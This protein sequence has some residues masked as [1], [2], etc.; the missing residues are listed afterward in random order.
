MCAAEEQPVVP[1]EDPLVQFPAVPDTAGQLAAAPP[2]SPQRPHGC[3]GTRRTPSFEK[4]AARV[5]ASF[6]EHYVAAGGTIRSDFTTV[7]VTM[8]ATTVWERAQRK[9]EGQIPAHH[10]PGCSIRPWGRALA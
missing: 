9:E 1:A 2:P 8:G 4:L 5:R 7:Y 3:W 10:T 6:L